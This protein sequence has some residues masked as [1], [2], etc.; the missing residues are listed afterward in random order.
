MFYN[1]DNYQKAWEKKF[2]LQKHSRHAQNC[3]NDFSHANKVTGFLLY[4][5][6]SQITQNLA[7]GIFA[8]RNTGG[9]SGG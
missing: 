6:F 4:E 1:D 9:T 7:L 5:G 2:T 8:F 3:C